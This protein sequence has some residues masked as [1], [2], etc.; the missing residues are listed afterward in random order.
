MP[1][2]CWVTSTW[3]MRQRICATALGVIVL[4]AASTAAQAA[5]PADFVPRDVLVYIEV[6]PELTQE[7][8]GAFALPPVAGLFVR[9]EG[10][11]NKAR[12]WHAVFW[13]N[14]GHSHADT[15]PAQL[16]VAGGWEQKSAGHA[17]TVFEKCGTPF[18]PVPQDNGD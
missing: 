15:T 7:L 9:D 2:R 14:H 8:V 12:L 3:Q 6:G 16:R 5:D 11:G 18:T 10:L 17:D 13:Y 1:T 4:L